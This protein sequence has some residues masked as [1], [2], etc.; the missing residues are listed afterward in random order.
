[1][2]AMRGVIGYATAAALLVPLGSVGADQP[3]GD[4]WRRQSEAI[5]VTACPAGGDSDS[6]CRGLVARRGKQAVRL[7]AGYNVGKVLW[8]GKASA[9]SPDVVLLGDSGGSGGAGDLFAVTFADP[10]HVRRLQGERMDWARAQRA[11]NRLHL[12]VAFNIE[13][14]N[15]VPHAGV[16]IVPLPIV[17]SHGDFAI[18]L[19]ALT[20]R[21]AITAR[22]S[23]AIAR[24]LDAWARAE[25]S[26]TMPNG[27]VSTVTILATLMLSGRT[28]EARRLLHT[29]W[30][31]QFHG[32]AAFWNSLCAAIVAHPWWTRFGLRR[33]P[34]ASRIVAASRAEPR[35]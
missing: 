35:L 5:V 19:A 24:E 1:M 17:W 16:S 11:S 23:R 34:E 27:T 30:P 20:K 9:A 3:L 28:L 8:S 10:I 15:G 22:E 21:P 31:R 32:E 4:I 12:E 33:I 2:S 29:A 7:G 6:S 18:D 26:G 14:F 13:Y 25:R